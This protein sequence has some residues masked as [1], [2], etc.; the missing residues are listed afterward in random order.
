MSPNRNLVKNIGFGEEA[1]HTFKINQQTFVRKSPMCFPLKHPNQIELNHRYDDVIE[2][3]LYRISIYKKL[4]NLL[5]AIFI[6][7]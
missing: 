4:N 2:K 1:T 3:A 6:E 5:S 7:K